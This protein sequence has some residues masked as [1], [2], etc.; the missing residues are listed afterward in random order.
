[1]S[2]VEFTQTFTVAGL[3]IGL[4]SYTTVPG[5]TINLNGG[6]AGAY[7][8]K[9][10]IVYSSTGINGGAPYSVQVITRPTF[11]DQ[12]M[13]SDTAG[14]GV[15]F[16][17]QN[18]YN[19]I[20]GVTVL[21]PV[22]GFNVNM[23]AAGDFYIAVSY[24]FIPSTNA[25][26]ANFNSIGGT[27]FNTTNPL[28]TGSFANQATIVKSVTIV[29]YTNVS[30]LNFSLTINGFTI[31]ESAALAIGNSFTYPIPLFLNDT[32]TLSLTSSGAAGAFSRVSSIEDP[33]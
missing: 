18:I 6:A 13:Y 24:S 15:A 21:S 28:I 11:G 7:V 2:Q 12:P 32:Q 16:N 27:T 26:Y 25:L 23:V 30:S 4:N 29:N 17:I 33:A 3:G 14:T 8:L 9:G 20:Q 1:M 22:L 19:P 31:Y 5:L 10:L